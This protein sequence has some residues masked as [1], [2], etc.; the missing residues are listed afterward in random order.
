MQTK[1]FFGFEADEG[2]LDGG[3]LWTPEQPIGGDLWQS[4][5]GH[6]YVYIACHEVWC[7]VGRMESCDHVR[8]K[9]MH[10]AHF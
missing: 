4:A 9:A 5:L 3:T 7:Y 8:F 10:S 6:R 1:R 2:P